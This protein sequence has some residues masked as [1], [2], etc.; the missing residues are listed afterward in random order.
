[1]MLGH[2]EFDDLIAAGCR[3]CAGQFLRAL[4]ILPGGI[5]VSG[6]EPVSSVRWSYERDDI[7][8]LVYRVE[9]RDCAAVLYERSDCPKC[10]AEKGL[11]RVLGPGRGL[12]PPAQCP[13]CDYEEL[14]VTAQIRAYHEFLHGRFSRRVCAAALGEPGFQVHRIDCPNCEQNLASTDA[15][16]CIACGRSS[17]L[18]KMR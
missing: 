1:M 8:D 16:A 14:R 15:H 11:E 7:H 2:R 3:S 4:A 9:C 5:L 6:G 18:K 12:T 10:G 13:Q 17:L